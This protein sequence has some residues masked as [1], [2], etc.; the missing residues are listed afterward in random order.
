MCRS[1]TLY[2]LSLTP[3]GTLRSMPY[4]ICRSSD[5]SYVSAS[6]VAGN[7]CITSS[8]MRYSNMLPLHDTSAVEPEACVSVRPSRNQ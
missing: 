1:R 8:G 4:A 2:A 6:S 5:P 3:Q 7:E